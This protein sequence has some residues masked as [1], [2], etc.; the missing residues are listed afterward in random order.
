MKKNLLY[1]AG[2][3][4]A[5]VSLLTGC[6]DNGDDLKY[7]GLVLDTEQ[8][9]I[10]M[11]KSD[12]GVIRVTEG[13]GNYRVAL[14]DENIAAVK[15]DGNLIRVT[16]MQS[17]KVD[18][19]VTD[20]AKKSTSARIVVKR[21]EELILGNESLKVLIGRPGYLSVYTGN[22]QYSASSSDESIAVADV[23]EDGKITVSGLARGTA[24][25]TITDKLG[26]SAKFTAVVSRQLLFDRTEDIYMLEV[27]VP[28]EINILDGNGGYT[29]SVSSAAYLECTVAGTKVLVKGK[30]CGKPN[31]TFTVKDA[32]GVSVTIRVTFMDNNYL[33]NL[34]LY[35]AF[36]PE[37]APFQQSSGVG[38]AVYS[39]E[40]RHSQLSVK[41]STL[42][43]ISTGY[44]LEFAGDLSVGGKNDAVMY[45]IKRG[46]V[47][48]SAKQP[49][50]DLRI[51]K[52]EGVWYWASFLTAGK[53]IRS[54]IVTRQTN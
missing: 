35:R 48:L 6:S 22:G 50:A 3:L 21:E 15:V 12:E 41:S 40:L 19:T 44:C 17:G 26:K 45:L 9:V 46:E 52:V 38:T 11:D 39:P 25:I 42:A 24:T 2:F 5:A 49:V 34:K 18:M 27:G 29:S 31:A 14:S 43:I 13:N 4:V 33:D 20:W 28:F 37:D 16:A 53:T 7:S 8:L 32:D 23:D 30:R 36:V 1:L 47:D 10:D 51:D 54:Y